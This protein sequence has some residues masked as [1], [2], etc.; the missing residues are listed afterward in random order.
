MKRLGSTPPFRAANGKLRPGS[1]ASVEYLR[2]GGIE[3]WV[4]IRSA[5]TA[6]P[7]LIMLHGGPGLGET[8]F[9]RRYN[10]VL[11]QNFTVVYWDQRG[12]GKS[13]DRD[14]PRESMTLE[15]FLSDLDEL[16]EVVRAR[17]GHDKIV[18]FGHSWGS[19]LGV[20]YTQRFPEKVAAYVGSGQIGN[21]PAA[22]SAS[23]AYA[24][25]EAQRQGNAKIIAK[26]DTIGAPP[27]PASSVFVERMCLSRLDGMLSP[28]VLWEL[29]KMALESDELSVVELPGVYR[30]FR[31]TM[32][33]MWRQV[34]QLN[35]IELAPVLE[36]PVFI[37]HGRKDHFVP[38][39]TTAAY[40]DV[41]TAP[42][43]QLV[44][45]EQSGH[46]PFMDEPMKFNAMMVDL[47]RPV[48]APKVPARAA[49]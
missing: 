28:K 14:I 6:N 37:F 15:Q 17:F 30:A 10:T 9:F 25:A 16:V 4:M 13:F 46:E 3:Q 33:A 44:W 34:S 11:E 26:L 5:N 12:A 38:A 32:D 2:L 48:V 19:V 27:Y 47:V 18:L 36:V 21:W 42:S 24:R 39:E 23:Y 49:S 22:E 31:W 43:K 35:L 8:A 40:F 29:A 20:L 41:L 7:P 45:F 1:V